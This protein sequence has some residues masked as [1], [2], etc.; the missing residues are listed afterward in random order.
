ML[1]KNKSYL[2]DFSSIQLR[3]ALARFWHGNTHFEV[4]LGAWKGVPYAKR[5]CWG[6]NL[7]K[8]E[9]D[10]H[11]L[12]VYPITQKVKERFCS[13][14]SL[15]HISTLVELMQ[16]TNTVTLAKFL[17]CYQYPRTICPPWSIFRLMDSMVPNGHKIVNKQTKCQFFFITFQLMFLFS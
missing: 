17:A 12:L 5:L 11:L 10:E 4:V 6:Y 13:T 9:D 14:L 2:C 3:K 15:T 1:Y 7:G 8:V 16:T